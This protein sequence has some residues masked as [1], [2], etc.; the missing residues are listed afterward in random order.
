MGRGPFGRLVAFVCAFCAAI[1]WPLL[2]AL[3]ACAPA[4]D[5]LLILDVSSSMQRPVARGVSRLML[6]RDA[7]NQTVAMVAPDA[8]IALRFYGSETQ[9]ANTACTDSSLKVPFAPAAR[10]AGPIRLALADA[11]ARGVTPI[12]YALEQAFADFT[13]PSIDHTIILISDG[14]EDCGGNPCNDAVAL[15]QHGFVV[16]AIGFGADA[17]G[18]RQL[19][20]IAAAAGGQYYAV[21]V[22]LQLQ[23]KLMQAL[24]VCPIALGPGPRQRLAG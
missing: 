5:A 12:A 3:A 15:H 20:C 17:A 9:N 2:P 8:R 13:D 21:P 10:N 18:A 1:V 24:G 16:N 14:G 19:Q 6:A 4:P 23:D 22:A 11:H 7:I